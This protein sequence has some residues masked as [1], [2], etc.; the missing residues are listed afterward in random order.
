MSDE[1]PGRKIAFD[2]IEE[3]EKIAVPIDSKK[4]V[5]ADNDRITARFIMHLEN[6]CDKAQSVNLNFT[7]MLKSQG[8]QLYD[9]KIKVT[10][11]WTSIN[12][13]WISEEASK[14]GMIILEN[15]CDIN[16]LRRQTLLKPDPERPFKP[17]PNLL[18]SVNGN[19]DQDDFEI[20]PGQF[21]IYSS[22]R[23]HLLR[24]KSSGDTFQARL[25][26]FPG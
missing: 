2:T 10:P 15:T 22:K 8:V 20:E 14:V 26:V 25:A 9:R 23:S 4:E 16:E 1:L 24:V 6:C 7:A 3:A 19:D 13:G 11:S 17:L 18:V 21:N 5:L 12:L